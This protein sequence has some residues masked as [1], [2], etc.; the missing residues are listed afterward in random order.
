MPQSNS[1][2]ATVAGYLKTVSA[3]LDDIADASKT[4]SARETR[5]Q[6]LVAE[7]IGIAQGLKDAPSKLLRIQMAMQRE[8]QIFTSVSNVLKT[9]HDTA[10]N[11]IGN[12]R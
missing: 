10:K 6:A 11:S 9:R 5:V 4:L 8:N 3:A 2:P 7:L 12:I 1:S